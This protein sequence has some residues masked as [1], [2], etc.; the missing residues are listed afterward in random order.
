MNELIEKM[1]LYGNEFYLLRVSIGP[2]QEFISEARKTRDLFMG[3]LLLSKATYNSMEPIS[4]TY[5]KDF[6]IYPQISESKDYLSSVPNLYMAVIPKSKLDGIITQME[7]E[8]K[9]FWDSLQETVNNK[10]YSDFGVYRNQKTASPFYINWV[11]VPLTIEDLKNSYKS[12]V[13]DSIE[14]LN[15]RKLTRTFESWDGSYVQKCSQCGH[16]EHTIEIPSF[17]KQKFRYRIKE[18]EKL[19]SICLLKRLLDPGDF[20][21]VPDQKFDSVIDVS[22]VIIKQSLE[23]KESEKKEIQDFFEI[24]S[25]I[26]EHV[27]I[28]SKSGEFYYKDYL[29]SDFF[30]KEY[31]TPNTQE[32]RVLCDEGNKKLVAVYKALGIKEP[33]KYYSIVMM[34]GDDM[35]HLMSGEV[36][37]ISG[38]IIG[39]KDFTLEYQEK[40]SKT[41]A[42]TGADISRLIKDRTK[43]NGLCVYSGG[44]ELLAFLPLATTLSTSN[45]A[46]LSFT[47]EFKKSGILQTSSAGIVILHH[48]DPLQKGLEEARK[49]VDKAKEWFED[50]D[51][52]II[53]LRLFSG[54]VIT[55]GFKWDLEIPTLQDVGQIQ[56]LSILERFVSFML[57]DH[58]NR[59]SPAFVHDFM[60]ELPSFYEH[61]RDSTWSLNEKMFKLEFQRLLKRHI[62]KK[63]KIWKDT[64][65]KILT[66]DLLM[67]LFVYMAN[68][69]KNK[70]MKSE[71][72]KYTKENFEH[73]LQIVLFLAREEISGVDLI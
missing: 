14:F 15:E 64:F 37:L 50:K 5:G 65:N 63:S 52:F 25:K 40:L 21:N 45:D 46:R 24:I 59:L 60:N 7:D 42:D 66:I 36:K 2:V 54:S 13:K 38:G 47:N 30:I 44:D 20:K 16:R 9:F 43:G 29:N 17:I 32:F 31:G 56:V 22:S 8:L 39:D 19:C 68:P 34:D 28:R 48:K 10:F 23:Q 12:K 57:K 73:I 69:D 71:Y 35:G 3:S 18:N 4:N 27:K 62:P 61:N 70:Q 6:I 72:R 11:V 55:C 33:S 53:T 1:K 51:A 67:E 58:D 41:L 26:R 49:N